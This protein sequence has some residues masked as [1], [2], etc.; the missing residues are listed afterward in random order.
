MIAARRDG[1]L[2]GLLPVVWRGG[3]LASPT[4]WH[5]VIHGALAVSPDVE[6]AI[7]REMAVLGARRVDIAALGPQP[8]LALSGILS[9]SG[10]R[11][12]VRV[13]QRSPYLPLSGTWESYLAGRSRNLRRT[14]RRCRNRLADLGQVSVTVST[15]EQDLDEQLTE[16]F[17]IEAS[18]WKHS[19]G[20][21]ITS[22]PETL[23]FYRELTRY[24][25]SAG[26]LRLVFLRLDQRAVA[27][28]LSLESGGRHYDIKVGHD[29]SLNRAGPGIVL[30]AAMLERAFSIGLESYEFL[31]D[32]EPYKLRWTDLWHERIR[33]QAFAPTVAGCLD[34]AVQVWG[35]TLV[36]RLRGR[37]LAGV[38]PGAAL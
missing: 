13:I 2:A 20:T 3:M 7:F 28:S 1:R 25:A 17:A 34:R 4:N 38:P 9:A 26:I 31:G 36:M 33:L 19:R 10:Y 12:S 21:A 35:R 5:S 6:A 15:G 16:G 22:R 14:L 37:S 8:A 11:T 29:A 24:A 23:Q 32:A 30:M 18:G 27:F